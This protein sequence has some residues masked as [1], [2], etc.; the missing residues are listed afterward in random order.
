MIDPGGIVNGATFAPGPVAPGSIVSIFG[1]DLADSI[2]ATYSAPLPWVSPPFGNISLFPG[3]DEFAAFYQSSSQW[4][5][6]LPTTLQAA[7]YFLSVSVAST[8]E[9]S[10]APVAFT[11]A[12]VAP[13]IFTWG[14]NHGAVLNGDYS[15]NTPGSP[16]AAGSAIM[17]YLTGQGAV[18]PPVPT[19]QAAPSSP[20]S[21]TTAATT[22][23][24]DGA[25]ASVS[26]SGLAPGYVGLCQVNVSIPDGLPTGQHKLMINIGGVNTNE[27]VFDTN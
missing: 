10:S 26:F 6:Q 16:A 18:D 5:V 14:T 3:S 4:N 1:I 20:L 21:Y 9:S 23:T 25:S 11:V 12:A 15:L 22:A 8:G 17:V 2:P 13:Y 24:I 27:V 7:K 19:R